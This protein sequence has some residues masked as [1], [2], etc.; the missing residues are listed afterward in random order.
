M[1]QITPAQMRQLGNWIFDRLA[2]V[3]MASGEMAIDK[4]V[5]RGALTDTK[6]TLDDKHET[7]SN[8]ILHRA[9]LVRRPASL[10]M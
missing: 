2:T 9:I 8:T 1:H 7:A 4:S 3:V 5:L 6:L 10:E